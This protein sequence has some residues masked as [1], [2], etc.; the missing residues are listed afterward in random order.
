MDSVMKAMVYHEYG[1]P[2]VL[3]LQNI[4]KPIIKSYEVLVK[5]HAASINWIDWHFLTSSPLLAR[6]MAGLL[7]PKNKVLGIDFARRVEAIGA[8]DFN[9]R[10]QENVTTAPKVAE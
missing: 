5:I 7:Q 1:S 3:E 8:M 9:D 4:E 2:D 6:L 10:E